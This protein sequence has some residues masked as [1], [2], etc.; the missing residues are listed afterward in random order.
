VTDLY[1]VII[2]LGNGDGTFQ[3]PKVVTAAGF[4]V[5]FSTYAIGDFNNDG[6][7]DFAVEATGLGVVEMFL[8][9]AQGNYTFKG[10]FSEGTGSNFPFVNSL[11]LADFNG[12]GVLDVATT[13]G[14]SESVSLLLGNGDGTLRSVQLFAGALNDSAVAFKVPGFQPWIA[15]ACQDTKVRIIKNTTP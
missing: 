7:L 1:R 14:F 15:M 11:L 4:D 5:G 13:D 3:A 12:D 10:T 2:Q 6:I 8:G 9:D